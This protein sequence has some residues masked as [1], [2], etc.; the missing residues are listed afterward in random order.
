[1]NEVFKTS[2]QGNRFEKKMFRSRK[3]L[4]IMKERKNVF[5]LS[6]LVFYVLVI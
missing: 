4:A 3:L 2:R 6:D 5:L 1:M